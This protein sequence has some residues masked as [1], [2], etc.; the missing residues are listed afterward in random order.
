MLNEMFFQCLKDGEYEA[1]FYALNRPDRLYAFKKLKHLI[2][3]DHQY[4]V[5]TELYS[6][7]ENASDVITKKLLTEVKRLMPGT[8]A[9]EIKSLADNRGLIR[10]YRGE[11]EK[12]TVAE[13]AVSWTI[14]KEVADWFRKR[15][16]T[17][18]RGESRIITGD[19]SPKF[20]AAL[21]ND[22]KEKEIV[23]IPGTVKIVA[24]D[25]FQPAQRED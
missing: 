24:V 10:I 17:L 4:S 18:H 21:I 16:D 7:S 25:V 9:E 22:R 20:V 14:D 11:W 8:V 1:A 15:F 2:P 5:F 3:I 23:V 12:S 13:R 19:V 6:D